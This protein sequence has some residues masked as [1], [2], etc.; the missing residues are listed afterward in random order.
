[1]I[2]PEGTRSTDNEIRLFKRGAFQLAIQANVPILP[3]II[4]GTGGILPKHGLIFGRGDHIKIRVLDP[5]SPESFHTD[6]PD[7]LAAKFNINMTGELKKMRMNN[8]SF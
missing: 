3:V 5:V 6:N 1:M 4:D 2:F 7:E 8:L